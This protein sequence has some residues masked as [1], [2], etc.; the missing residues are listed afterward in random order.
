MLLIVNYHY[1]REDFQTP[2]P[3]IFG[4]APKDFKKQLEEVSKYG[5]YISETDLINHLD[6]IS[7]LP[8]K[9]IMVT[10]DDGLKEQYNLAQ[11]ILNHL[12]IPA[13]FYTNTKVLVERTLLN[14]H[15]VHIVRSLLPPELIIAQIEMTSFYAELPVLEKERIKKYAI[16]HYIYDKP[17]NAILKYLLN[18]ILPTSLVYQVFL[19]MSA[20]LG[21]N[22]QNEHKNLY[23]SESEILSLS[24]WQTIGSHSHDHLPIGT[25]ERVDAEN[26]IETSIKLLKE[27]GITA[28]SFS[29]PYGSN[30]A[31][32][33]TKNYLRQFG[34]K[35]ALTMNREINYDFRNPYLLNRCDNNDI[36]FGKSLNTKIK[37]Q[38]F[39]E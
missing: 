25:L 9:S 35:F 28:K 27:L 29:Y 34:I 30:E 36:L 7:Q 39:D 33:F 31:V 17:E 24:K 3:A 21:L 22:L 38:F 11:P 8:K 13:T 1:I 20:I 18:F 19:E 23:M 2:F 14:V 26:E 6:G 12:G 15:L 4:I 5:T 10:F 16:N 37:Q 32:G